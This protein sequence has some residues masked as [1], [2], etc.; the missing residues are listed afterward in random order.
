MKFYFNLFN[1]RL[2]KDFDNVFEAYDHLMELIGDFS[3]DREV[4]E[5]YYTITGYAGLFNINPAI[6]QARFKDKTH[7]DVRHCNFGLID[8]GMTVYHS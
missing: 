1:Y 6:V 7:T 5:E 3:I 4:A 2:E 8:L